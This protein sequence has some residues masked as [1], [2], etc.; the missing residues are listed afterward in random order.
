MDLVLL[1]CLVWVVSVAFELGF[2]FVCIVVCFVMFVLSCWFDLLCCGF[3]DRSFDFWCLLSCGFGLF[4]ML[5]C[6]FWWVLKVA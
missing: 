6:C 3:D 4:M 2:F 1:D 5:V